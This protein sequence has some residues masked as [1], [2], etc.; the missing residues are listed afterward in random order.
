MILLEV[1]MPT[2]RKQGQIMIEYKCRVLSSSAKL[3]SLKS[4]WIFKGIGGSI[5]KEEW[6]VQTSVEDFE[7]A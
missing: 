5:R 4:D 7:P 2:G 1:L 6:I 3:S